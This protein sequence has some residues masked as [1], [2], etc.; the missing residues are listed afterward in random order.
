MNVVRPLLQIR[1]PFTPER[2]RAQ[3]K[4]TSHWHGASYARLFTQ[5]HFTHELSTRVWTL[6]RAHGSL[7]LSRAPVLIL[8][9]PSQW[10]FNHC[11]ACNKC[12]Y[13]EYHSTLFDYSLWAWPLYTSQPI[14]SLR[15]GQALNSLSFGWKFV[16]SKYQTSEDCKS[17]VSIWDL[18]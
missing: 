18:V 13:I 1:A 9:V 14:E 6:Y 11:L 5:I 7:G 17:K 16:N 3:R 15:V 8:W 2:L 12:F 10:A 4:Q